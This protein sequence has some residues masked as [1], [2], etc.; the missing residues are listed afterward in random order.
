MGLPRRREIAGTAVSITDYTETLDAIDSS[1]AADERIYVCCAPASS[2]MFARKDR[3]LARAF[4][5]AAIVTPDGMGVVYAARL[6][7]EKIED[8]VYG[9]DLMLL[10]LERAAAVGTPTYFYGGFD[11]DA[12]ERLVAEYREQFPA[13][14]VAG[15]W[16]PPHRP[17]T[18]DEAEQ[19]A[20]AINDSGARIVWVGIGSPKQEIW[21]QA[22]RAG[23][24]APVL[25]GVGAAFDFHTGRTKQAPSWMQRSGLEWLYRIAQDPIRLGRRYLLTLPH[26]VGIVLLQRLRGS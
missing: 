20:A 6:L 8:R 13:L 7:G 11:D 17:L 18:L 5:E 25:V 22:N 4:A 24:N 3:K 21:M 16:S 9:P 15:A 10:Q 12:L 1:L 19:A 2:L 14:V 23:L 26:F